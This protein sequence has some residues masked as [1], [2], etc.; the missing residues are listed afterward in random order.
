MGFSQ[1]AK[2]SQVRDYLVKGRDIA[3]K[4]VEIF[5]SLLSKEFLPSASAWDTLPN[6]STVAPFS[7]KLM[8]YQTATLNSIG[9][10]HYGRAL[11]L[12][13]RRDLA[14]NYVRLTAEVLQYA[15]D[16]TNLMIENGWFEQPP[17]AIDRN[18]LVNE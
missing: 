8:M 2:S 14:S 4:H 9:I 12:S 5:G 1:V 15:E 16:G 11:G 13:P 3:D 17:Q 6:A 10:T 18:Q 7:D